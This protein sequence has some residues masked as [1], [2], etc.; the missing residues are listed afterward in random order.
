MSPDVKT[1]P[2]CGS[3]GPPFKPGR[4]YHF[5][6]RDLDLAG[7]ITCS[8]TNGLG[9]SSREQG[10]LCSMGKPAFTTGALLRTEPCWSTP[11]QRSSCRQLPK[12]FVLD[13][14]ASPS[15]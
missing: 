5:T 1:S 10:P 7:S 6:F 9:E 15:R 8:P 13:S 2:D 12:I 11:T 3:G 4:L 14:T